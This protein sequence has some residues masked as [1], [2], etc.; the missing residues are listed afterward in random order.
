MIN[1]NIETQTIPFLACL[2]NCSEAEAARRVVTWQTFDDSGQRRPSLT[3]LRH[4]SIS[5]LSGELVRLNEAG[6][7]V[8][9]SVNQTNG[10]GRTK[11]DM[12]ALRGLHADLDRKNASAPFARN[13][14][15]PTPNLLTNTGN[16]GGHHAYWL[17]THPVNCDGNPDRIARHEQQ[18]RQIQRQYAHLGADPAVTDISRPL[19]SPGF[20]NR[21][22]GDFFLVTFE[23]L[24]HE[25]YCPD[26]IFP[27]SS[28]DVQLGLK[29]H[30]AAPTVFSTNSN[31]SY[32]RAR[33]YLACIDGAVEGSG[34]S[35]QTFSAALKLISLFGLSADAVYDL[36]LNDFNPRCLPP[37]EP[38]DLWRKVIEAQTHAEDRPLE[39]KHI[40]TAKRR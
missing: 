2:L 8:S 14:I 11:G 25:R 7:A 4:G 22:R 5:H 37:W 36:L 19:R 18:L 27:L 28:P 16:E 17:F 26:E 40:T 3:S 29:K 23:M 35:T 38:E 12:V 31:L 30:P 15:S 13:S 1:S 32:R 39:P 33:A 34:G 20:Y 9:I 6:A 24:N 10:Q 21:K